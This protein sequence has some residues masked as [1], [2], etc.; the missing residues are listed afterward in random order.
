M[1]MKLEY[2]KIKRYTKNLSCPHN[3]ACK[4]SKQTCWKCGWN[5]TVEQRRMEKIMHRNGG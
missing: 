3:N 1:A 4:C 5:P 2:V